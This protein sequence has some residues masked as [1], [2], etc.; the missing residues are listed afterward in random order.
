MCQLK[1]FQILLMN[2]KEENITQNFDLKYETRT[3]F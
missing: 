3:N 1:K 2:M